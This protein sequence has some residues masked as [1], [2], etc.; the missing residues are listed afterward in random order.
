M[1]ASKP[2]TPLRF[3]GKVLADEAGGRLFIADSNHNRIVVA[4]LDGKLQ[5]VI[6]TG[7]IG[8]ADGGVRRVQ[9]QSSARHGA[10]RRHA[11]RGRHRES[12]A[13]QGRSGDAS[14]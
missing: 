1:R 4:T 11:V 14:A 7:A 2:A 3:P 8:R 5:H 9:L 10:G 12:F 6:G 13:A